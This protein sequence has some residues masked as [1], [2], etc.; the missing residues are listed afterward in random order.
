MAEAAKFMQSA[1]ADATW[2]SESAG[3]EA[4]AKEVEV[5][6]DTHVDGTR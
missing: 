6:Q 3:A 5:R 1:K 4:S 2:R